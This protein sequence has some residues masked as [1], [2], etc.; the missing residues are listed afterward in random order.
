MILCIH[1]MTS[2]KK[3]YMN[4]VSDKTRISLPYTQDPFHRKYDTRIIEKLSFKLT[5][6]K[7][8]GSIL[9]WV[10]LIVQLVT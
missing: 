9:L 10:H 1:I 4:F 3:F 5:Y 8:C 7:L 2:G 6:F